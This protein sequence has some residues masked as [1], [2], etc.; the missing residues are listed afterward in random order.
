MADESLKDPIT[1]TAVGINA[2][3]LPVVFSPAYRMYVLSQS[4]DFT[5]VTGK[6]NEAGQGAYDAQVKNDEQDVVLADHEHRIQQ[7]RIEVDD[8]ELRITANTNAIQLL[9]VRL[10]TA[11]GQIVT[12]RSDVDYLTGKVVEIEGDMVS[13]SAATDQVIQSAGG[14]FIIGNVVTPTTDKL[15]VIGDITASSS[16]KV[17]G[18]KVVGSR[19]TGF[20]AATGSALKGV[21]NASQTYTVGATY[22]QSEVQAMASGLTAAR[23]RIKALED[24]MRS[25]GL[26]D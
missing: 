1:V 26:I 7:L 20:T 2:A 24:A 10:T 12:L 25:H 21:F 5:R 6:A 11:E 4:L 17:N 23:Q 15:Q 8:H 3:S 22:T 19:V 13:K 9:D 16:Y 18:V 14:S